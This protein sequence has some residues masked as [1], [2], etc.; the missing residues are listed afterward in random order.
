MASVS[1]TTTYVM[2][3]DLGGVSKNH[4][5]VGSVRLSVEAYVFSSL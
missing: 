3:R 4:F 2:L 5:V 1:K